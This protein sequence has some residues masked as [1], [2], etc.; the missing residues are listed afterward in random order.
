VLARPAE[1][2]SE[3]RVAELAGSPVAL[4]TALPLTFSSKQGFRL[5]AEPITGDWRIEVTSYR[6]EVSERDGVELLAY[7]WH[8]TGQ[9]PVT[10]PH[11]HARIR[12]SWVDLAK[13]HLPTGQVTPA[14]V[15][16]CLIADFGAEPLRRDWRAILADA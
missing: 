5:A 6:Y 8:P 15:V 11:L 13:S 12:G 4:R 16:R 1:A 9:S 14:E 7:H 2:G 3:E 10:V